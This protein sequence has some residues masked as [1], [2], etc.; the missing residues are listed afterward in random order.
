[1][2][3]NFYHKTIKKNRLS[4]FVV[5]MIVAASLF[6]RVNSTLISNV[7]AA[8]ED[9]DVSVTVEMEHD[10]VKAGG[11]L[12]LHLSLDIPEGWYLYEH[13]MSAE[14]SEAPEDIITQDRVSVN[15]PEPRL[16]YDPHLDDEIEIYEGFLDGDMQVPI[17][18]S[19]EPGEYNITVTV[20]YQ[21][22]TEEICYI[23]SRVQRDITFEI[24]EG[25]I[26]AAPGVETEIE[27]P[28]EPEPGTTVWEG[29]N[30]GLEERLGE[31]AGIG[32]I[33]LISYLAGLA[34]TLTPCVYPMIPV[35]IAV[36]GASKAETKTVAF[37]RSLIYV[38][39]IGLTYAAVGT[40]AAASG[41][42][43]GVQLQHPLVYVTLAVLFTLFALSMFGLFEINIPASWQSKIQAGLRGKAGLLGLLL[44]GMLSGV[45]VT[46]CGAPI[47][48]AA[49]SFIVA[50][51]DLLQGFVIF[52]A[53]AWGMGTPL[54]LAGTFSGAL[55]HLPESGGW[56]QLVKNIM[57]AALVGAS[58]YFIYL[59]A[60]LSPEHFSL[61]I[62]AVLIVAAVYI[63]AFDRIS[64]EV[65]GWLRARKS[66]G[67]LLIMGAVYLVLPHIG[68]QPG[69]EAESPAID[70]QTSIEASY[71]RAEQENK[72]I[73]FYFST[74]QCPACRR[75]ERRTF[76]DSRVVGESGNFIPVKYHAS[77]LHGE[78]SEQ[79]MDVLDEFGI[80]GFP[81]ILLADPQGN[82]RSR[83]EGV[84]I[85]PEE[86]AERMRDFRQAIR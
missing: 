21:A 59:S 44:T 60:L 4:P 40:L 68:L 10:A 75:L 81:T 48:F 18:A 33:L 72:P 54:V 1:M 71:E 11:M 66:A 41:A 3:N 86:L 12:N 63:G 27:Q 55:Q 16:R 6:V 29:E 77:P 2:M 64:P 67:I 80:K 23:P 13:M 26:E 84:F 34:L 53:I 49:L 14:V 42:A 47:V 52:S 43:F 5:C 8:E 9:A 35:T 78:G 22:C 85:G 58:L 46:S 70:W 28:D 61:L 73:I 32:L 45:V 30:G 15:W 17:A 56:Q 19:A 79:V 83:I 50:T 36:I 57:G 24:K 82:T 65:G 31:E 20:G 25:E 76:P 7:I 37:M 74:D 62:S 39:G 69:R 38:L 51:G